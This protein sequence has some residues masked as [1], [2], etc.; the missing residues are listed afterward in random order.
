MIKIVL[1]FHFKFKI[2]GLLSIANVKVSDQGVRFE[3]IFRDIRKI[4]SPGLTYTFDVVA[5]LL[6]IE[7]T[8]KC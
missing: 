1:I 5:F 2:L 7:R 8:E 3:E 6:P 4:F